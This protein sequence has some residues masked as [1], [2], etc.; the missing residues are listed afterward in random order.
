ML[1]YTLNHCKAIDVVSQRHELGL[2]AFELS[3]EEWSIVEQ[4]CNVLKIL[5]DATMFFSHSTPSLATV[6]PAMDLIDETLTTHMLNKQLLPSIH[7]AAGL[8][9]K[10]L[11]RYYELTDTSDVYC[12]AMILHPCHKLAYFQCAKWEQGWIELAHTL[13]RAEFDRSYSDYANGD[14]DDGAGYNSD[15]SIVASSTVSQIIYSSTT[16][17]LTVLYRISLIT[18]LHLPHQ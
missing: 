18:F 15:A 14:M 8:A 1:E 16:H 6:I 12:V 5:K 10:T 9:K 3:D 2:R 7:A 13:V 4:L 17:S 11:N